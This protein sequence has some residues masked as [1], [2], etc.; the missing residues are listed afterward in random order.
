M[1]LQGK[2]APVTGATSG[3]GQAIAEA[4][5]QEGAHVA[6]VGCNV[7]RG[8]QVVENIRAAGGSAT[9]IAADLASL[10]A[11][12]SLLKEVQYRS[13]VTSTW[14]HVHLWPTNSGIVVALHERRE[15]AVLQDAFQQEQVP[16]D[17]L[18]SLLTS[19]V[20]LTPEGRV[21][22]INQTPL[23]SAQLQR[24]DVLGKPFAQ[25]FWWSDAPA[26]QQHVR[27][28]I[29]QASMGE[30]IHFEARIRTHA[31]GHLERAATITPHLDGDGHVEYL[32]YTSSDITARKQI[33]D[34]LRAVVDTMLQ[35]VWIARPDG[36]VEY[37]NRR[38]R[39]YT[40]MTTEQAQGDG[41]L[42]D[43]HPDDRQTTLAAWR[44]A[45]QTGG[46][47]EV[48]FRLR[49]GMTGAYRW[50]LVRGAPCKDQQ[51]TIVKWV[52]TCTD[53]EEQ[54]RIEEA[55]RQSQERVNQLLNSSIIGIFLAE[56]D[57]VVEANA[58]F[59]RMTGYT[60]E[61]LRQRHVNWASMTLPVYA[62]LAQQ[63]HQELAIQNYTTPFE[64]EL[65]C[66]DGSRLPVLMGGVT[67]Q[68]NMLQGI[69]FVLDNSARKELEQRKDNFLSMASHELKTPLTA[70][71]I[72][73]QLVRK[74]L[75]RQGLAETAA[76]L[77]R[78]EEPVKQLERLIGE[79]LDVSKIQAGRLEY[80]REPVDL[81]ALLH[82]VAETM[83]QM[84]T[85]HTIVVRG[86][87]AHLL[88]GDKGRLE[89]VFINLLSNA[90]KYSPDACTVEIEESASAEIVTIRVRDHGIGIPQEQREKIFER[91]YR[92][93]D[94]SQR[95]VPGLGMGLYIVAEIVK[96]H[97]GT[98]VVESEVGKGSTFTVAL[99]LKRD[100]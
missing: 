75:V 51:G 11:V 26:V 84:S 24:A 86:A 22:S 15:P 38:W 60:R 98:I 41:W 32:I 82:E 63:V 72:Q 4:F 30:T 96:Q 35:I 50:F 47:Y 70:V 10:S 87:T 1:R 31:G 43:V 76:A 44:T 62:S 67:F 69:G 42:Q 39:D 79:L 23:T 95:A 49:Y 66:K 97:G 55:L 92:V 18:E 68:D 25:T 52:G 61:D 100:A 65:V 36:S 33:E 16:Q 64:T 46:V 6:V 8:K 3:I 40:S 81:D 89:Q 83:Q 80:V 37:V 9:F 88:V 78:I 5:A 74:R 57:D 14:L 29:A 20:I 12:D 54:K 13:L 34:E 99:P 59:L 71:K 91:F 90:I 56:G 7:Q 27:A 53:I 19:V 48:E 93:G 2:T 45:L 73:T 17:I 28:S 77:A 21:L 85:T 58:T 94:L